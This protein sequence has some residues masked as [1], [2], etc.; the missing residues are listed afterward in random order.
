M[1]ARSAAGKSGE[2]TMLTP[3]P[4]EPA[5][6]APKRK[7]SGEFAAGPAPIQDLVGTGVRELLSSML[8]AATA[9]RLGDNSAR[10]RYFGTVT[11]SPQVFRAPSEANTPDAVAA[12]VRNAGNAPEMSNKTAS[13][14]SPP[15]I[16]ASLPARRR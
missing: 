9:I 12:G 5:R 1:A 8:D 16:A 11:P 4:P 2:G 10:P 7:T 6:R 13:S 3:P 14:G 15:R